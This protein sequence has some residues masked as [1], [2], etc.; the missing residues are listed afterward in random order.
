MKRPLLAVCLAVTCVI[1]LWYWVYPPSLPEYV[2]EGTEEWMIY[3]RIVQ[4][5]N[6]SYYGKE[7]LILYL[8]D[9]AVFSEK[10]SNYSLNSAQFSV[11]EQSA[12]QK[13]LQ[14]GKIM[15]YVNLEENAA[16]ET[17]K[18]GSFILLRGKPEDFNRSDNPGEFDSRLYYA[19]LGIN[20]CIKNGEV[21]W[22]SGSYN[23]FREKLWQV[24]CAL[25]RKIDGVMEEKTASVL[26]T[27]LL[28]D[29]QGMDK[30][31]KSLY[32]A[33]G[34]AH[35]LAISGLHISL[36]GMGLY[37]LLRKVSLPIWFS[38]LTA[39]ACICVY[40]IFTGAGVSAKRAIGMFLIR[41]LAE[42]L[43]RGYDMLTA[44]GVLL[45]FLTL[46]QPFYLYHSGFLLSFSALFGIGRL[47]PALQ[48]GKQKSKRYREGVSK[49]FW[50]E[51]EKVRQN[52]FSSLSVTAATL[53]VSCWYFYEFPIYGVF[54]NLLV[55]PLLPVVMYLGFCILLLPDGVWLSL[56]AFLL[57][58]ILN[59]FEWLCRKSLQLPCQTFVRG[60]PEGWQVVLY[61]ALLLAAVR[62]RRVPERRSRL[63]LVIAAI[64]LFCVKL[65]GSGE[66]TFLDVGQG[67][68]ICIQTDSGNAYLVDCGS[69]S[70]SDVGKNVVASFLK[71]KGISYVTAVIITHPDA[72]HCNGLE[73]LLTAGYEGRIGALLLPYVGEENKNE[74]YLALEQM[75]AEYDILVGYLSKGMTW[76][77]GQMTFR[78]LHPQKSAENEGVV[79]SD[80]GAVG[81]GADGSEAD[82]S[83][84][85]DSNAYSIVLHIESGDF[86]VLL[87]GDIEGEGEI[88][89][90]KALQEEG[91]E[92]I[93][94]LKVAHH[95][96]KYSTSMEFLESVDVELAIISCGEDNRYGHPHKETLERL[97]KE[98]AAVWTTSQYG[99]I[100][101]RI[102]RNGSITLEN[103][104]KSN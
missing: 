67:D 33:G 18:I 4:K 73:G 101:V 81:V 75:A 36:I 89:L 99:A 39:G 86:S 13:I 61:V 53:P 23:A 62:R 91:I 26:K 43:G 80:S 29:G 63:V 12:D 3:G 49:W 9:Y 24:R 2:P 28:G 84:Y 68:G 55:L 82:N 16:Q 76:Q 45:L 88:Q 6:R 93:N 17:Q 50:M 14:N 35:I 44:L 98:G 104:R 69:S 94:I 25:E 58:W 31:I 42:I 71:Y 59:L 56:A 100:I 22:E 102:K 90:T 95:G 41:M 64:F 38:A 21:L 51:K 7:Q 77:D 34:I 40:G 20:F 15:C 79:N 60:R 1:A 5:E 32:Q 19:S 97:T 57:E 47:L 74:N 65:P 78:C 8:T 87:T 83:F 54:L 37:H 72:D 96:S 30:E 46:Q 66:I 103:G 92:K 70:R 85:A 27:I 48:G 52:F 11:Q 10:N